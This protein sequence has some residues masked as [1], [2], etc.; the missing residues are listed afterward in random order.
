MSEYIFSEVHY[1]YTDGTVLGYGLEK[2]EE[3]VRCRDCIYAEESESG[4]LRC[5][6]YLVD[7]WDY[8]NDEPSI[9]KQVEPNEFCAWGERRQP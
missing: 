7:S 9:G 1:G 4:V 2:Q 3:I 5:H 8:Y 6:G